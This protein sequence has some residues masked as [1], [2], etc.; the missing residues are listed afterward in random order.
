[1]SR[2]GKITLPVDRSDK[3][4]KSNEIKDLAFK[5]SFAAPVLKL[6]VQKLSG[7][8]DLDQCQVNILVAVLRH[9]TIVPNQ[10]QV[11]KINSRLTLSDLYE[12]CS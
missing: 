4:R 10:S 3:V 7:A 11:R 5:A 12:A 9:F 8:R 6:Q 2:A 1:M